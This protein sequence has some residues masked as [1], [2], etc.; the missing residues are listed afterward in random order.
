MFD[1]CSA[2]LPPL[3][4]FTGLPEAMFS[5]SHYKQLHTSLWLSI[6]SIGPPPPPARQLGSHTHSQQMSSDFSKMTT[7]AFEEK[8]SR[9][10]IMLPPPRPHTKARGLAAFSTWNSH[11]LTNTTTTPLDS[12]LASM[13]WLYPSFSSSIIPNKALL[14]PGLHPSQPNET[15]AL[16]QLKSTPY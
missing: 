5:Y 14:P 10:P 1:G 16:V 3:P 4:V 11:P 7:K 2:G 13:E 8:P 12:H 15:A 9:L 6:G